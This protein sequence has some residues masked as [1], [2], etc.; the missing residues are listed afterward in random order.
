MDAGL[1]AELE[2]LRDTAEHLST[3]LNSIGDAVITCDVAATVT[4]MNPVAEKLTGWSF[5]QARGLPAD[6]I[7]EII[8]SETRARVPSPIWRALR[9]PSAVGLGIHWVLVRRDGTEVRIA[10]S[11]APIR[12]ADG[13]V[14]GAVLVFRDVTLEERHRQ[15]IVA[16]SVGTLAAGAAHEINN[17][18]GYV[19]ANLD[20]A[21]EE[22]RALTWQPTAAQLDELE[23]M[24]CQA[25]S[26]AERVR[27][28]VRGLNTFA[29]DNELQRKVVVDIRPVL[30]LATDMAA[31]EI[32]HRARL[33]EHFDPVPLV[34]ADE[35]RLGQ[36]FTNLL[37]NAAQALPDGH[38]ETHEVRVT[39]VTDDAGR[40][41]IEISD[42]GPGI[43][44]SIIERI[45]EPFFT[46]K[47]IGL[48]TGLGLSVSRNIVNSM[49]GSL[50]VRSEEGHGA[51]FRV[52]LPP[53][54]VQQAAPPVEEI[55]P[56]TAR[57]AEVL[58]VDDDVALG[59][60][61]GRILRGHAVTVVT[62]AREALDLLAAGRT[63]DIVF[64][65]LM[66]PEMSGM[67][68]HD[69]AVR[70]FPDAAARMVFVTGGAFTAAAVAFLARVPN[71]RLE[72][73]FDP[74]LVRSFVRSFSESRR[75]RSES[76]MEELR[77]KPRTDSMATL[78]SAVG[79][80][81]TRTS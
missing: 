80:R 44:P 66:M 6:E 23:A 68:F 13:V 34:E 9:E 50:Q 79:L 24:L 77:P 31:N 17:P 5:E 14:R 60:A 73:P 43:A 81:G 56:E 8:D 74:A 48:G 69:E 40:A 22:I 57:V 27:R 29:R 37:V 72:K 78:R 20:V 42:T 67:D 18:L 16:A 54:A 3:T 61:F 15:L 41:V 30:R 63:F 26:G 62:R 39:T 11:C 12:G 4:R 38:I 35:A 21:L 58:F 52:V 64:S 36:V 7:F 51:S 28:I 47:P 46:T 76:G 1:R 45:F 32:R 55:H 25:R 49:G 65:D 33:I 53:A 71:E 75:P 19:I 59:T 10:D 2:T 70:R